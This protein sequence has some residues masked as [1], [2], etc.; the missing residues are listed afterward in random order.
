MAT[1]SFWGLYNKQLN[2]SFLYVWRCMENIVVIHNSNRIELFVLHA[3][4]IAG[5]GTGLAGY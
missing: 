3:T 4:V 1:V 2:Y 5:E